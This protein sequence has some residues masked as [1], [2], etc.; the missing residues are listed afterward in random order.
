MAARLTRLTGYLAPLS[1]LSRTVRDAV[2]PPTCAACDRQVATSGGVCPSCWSQMRFLESPMVVAGRSAFASCRSAVAY[3]GPARRMAQ[4]FKFAD[5]TDL[6]PTLAHWMVRAAACLEP[7]YVVLPVP[8]HRNRLLRRRFNQ[9]AELARHVATATGHIYL[10]DT[11]LRTRATRQQVGLKAG[12]RHA[13]VRGAFRVPE[14]KAITIKG[15]IRAVDRRCLYDRRDAGSL[16]PC[17]V[18][19]GRSAGGL[20]DIRARSGRGGYGRD[21]VRL[22]IWSL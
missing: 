16:F 15:R 4:A 2:M 1:N 20:P 21:G 8:L 11:L 14:A 22:P 13:N 12:E 3:D 7:G 18:A 19:G 9:A 17:P 5:R 6:A 10:P